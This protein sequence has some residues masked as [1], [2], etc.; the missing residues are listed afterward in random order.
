M[1]KRKVRPGENSA[2][3][4]QIN[5]EKET[6]VKFSSGGVAICRTPSFAEYQIEHVHKNLIL[7]QTDMLQFPSKS[8]INYCSY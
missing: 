5:E 1:K 8:V 6:S 4:K 7:F 2:S 3:A